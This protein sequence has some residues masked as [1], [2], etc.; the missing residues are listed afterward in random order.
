MVRLTAA[1]ETSDFELRYSPVF[2]LRAAYPAS[3]IR[4]IGTIPLVT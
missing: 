3:A 2:A 1:P 4:T